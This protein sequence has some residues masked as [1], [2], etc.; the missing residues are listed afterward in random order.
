MINIKVKGGG[1]FCSLSKQI[2]NDTLFCWIECVECCII[3]C[4]YFIFGILGVMVLTM[5]VVAWVRGVGAVS[6]LQTYTINYLLL[7][8]Q[9]RV[10]LG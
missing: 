4:I 10:N 3:F 9:L 5:N 2:C 1:C 8:T 6:Y 7:D